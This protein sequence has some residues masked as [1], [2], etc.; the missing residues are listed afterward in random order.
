V[1]LKLDISRVFDSLCWSFLLELLWGMGFSQQ[2]CARVS[3][4]MYSATTKVIVNGVPRRKIWRTHG[5][6]Q[7]DPRSPMFFVMAMKVLTQLLVKAV[8][9]NLLT[10]FRGISPLQ[11]LGVYADD[12]MLFVQDT[13]GCFGET[14]RLHINYLKSSE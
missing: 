6:R 8:D 5:L 7:G 2:L 3:S 11:A 12:V 14:T 1:L 4:L 10:H 13:V 9:A